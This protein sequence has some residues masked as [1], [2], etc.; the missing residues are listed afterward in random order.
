MSTKATA[1]RKSD[2]TRARI[3]AAAREQFARE[4]Y[5]RTTIRGVASDADIDPSMVMRYFGSK[6][7]LFLAATPTSLDIPD[8]RGV[9]R[10]RVGEA[11]VTHFFRRWEGEGGDETLQILLRT[12]ASN[13]DAAERMRAVFRKQ[14]LP[15]VVQVRGKAGSDRAASLIAS[16]M[17][18]LAYCLYILRLPPL[19]AAPRE[20]VVK[21]V[22]ATIQRYLS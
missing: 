16:Q 2:E 17:L 22:G 9:A 1:P 3:L 19:V 8:L 20:E 7:G 10:S 15:A 21:S 12:A 14:I 4:G 11:L 18:G 6:E 5:E 13:E